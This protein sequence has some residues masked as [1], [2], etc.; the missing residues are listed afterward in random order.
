M[1]VMTVLRDIANR[2]GAP[3]MDYSP[4]TALH[5]QRES[6]DWIAIKAADLIRDMQTLPKREGSNG[7]RLGGNSLPEEKQ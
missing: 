6:L 5:E 4:E 1:D 2:A 7:Y 3:T